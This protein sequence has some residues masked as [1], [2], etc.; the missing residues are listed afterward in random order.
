MSLDELQWAYNLGVQAGKVAAARPA[1]KVPVDFDDLD[2]R[3]LIEQARNGVSIA[4]PKAD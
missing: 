3:F 4:E 1:P 2:N